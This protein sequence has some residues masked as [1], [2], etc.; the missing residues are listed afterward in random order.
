[1]AN[2]YYHSRKYLTVGGGTITGNLTMT[3]HLLFSADNT[4]DIG[5]SGATRPRDLFLGRNATIGGTL[6]VTGAATFSSTVAT[7]A[8]TVTGAITATTTITSSQNMI[9]TLN[10]EARGAGTTLL[11]GTTPTNG[12]YYR[13]TSALSLG[14]GFF[15]RLANDGLAITGKKNNASG[16]VAIGI[17]AVL[18]VTTANESTVNDNYTPLEVAYETSDASSSAGYYKLFSFKKRSLCF[19][20]T[21]A[22][23]S[24]P[25][26]PEAGDLAVVTDAG[27]GYWTL[28]LYNG[29]NWIDITT[30]ATLA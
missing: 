15:N 2:T 23:A 28:A 24:M 13:N 26:S 6:G 12:F 11:M 5:A 7:G 10:V 8:L 17:G 21:S 20:K 3:G 18:N 1:M 29:T 27:A 16:A 14:N 9:S 25:A 30:G 19:R 4:Y 22:K